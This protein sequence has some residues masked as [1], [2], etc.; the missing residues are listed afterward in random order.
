MV[1]YRFYAALAINDDNAK[2]VS[3]TSIE[4]ED[5]MICGSGDLIMVAFYDNVRYDIECTI[6]QCQIK[7][8]R[9]YHKQDG[10]LNTDKVEV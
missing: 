1:D 10:F 4:V 3:I 6:D 8:C 2:T 9:V 7:H 5:V